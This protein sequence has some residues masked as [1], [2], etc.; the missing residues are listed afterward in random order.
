MSSPFVPKRRTAFFV[1]HGIGQQDPFE[2]LDVF[3][4]G[5]ANLLDE[6][7][8]DFVL[9]HQLAERAGASGGAWTESFCRFSPKD[10]DSSNANWLIDV[11]EYYW[12]YLTQEKIGEE[13]IWL[14]LD[15]TIRGAIRF[16]EENNQLLDR[17][18][19][20][21]RPY[22]SKLNEILQRLRWIYPLIRLAIAVL[23]RF[24]FRWA[25]LLR[26]W[27]ENRATQFIV[28]YIGDIAIY[29]T[30]DQ[31]SRH[32]RVR[33]QIL[34]E[35]FKLLEE[36]VT[37]TPCDQVILAGHSL[38][39]VIAYDTLNRLSILSSHATGS[40][41]PLS[42]LGGLVTFGSPLDKIA[43]FFREHTAQSQYVRR[44]ILEQLYSFKR[45]PFSFH[46]NAHVVV[47]PIQPVLEPLPWVNYYND[48]DPISGYLDFY[49]RLDNVE[50]KLASG[51]GV[52]HVEYWIHP[53][54]YA[55]IARR[56]L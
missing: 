5:I 11:H 25:R 34:K 6:A 33:Q 54:F 8:V 15:T 26:A 31:K 41:M 29:S 27:L 42:K 30:T 49:H 2:T 12:A 44:Q 55:D 18:K 1:V 10:G 48:K 50:L 9:S 39:S 13:E 45:R 17:F 37:H 51:W 23:K 52:A 53:P 28:D 7:G 47:S 4:R 46:K 36:V 56:F 3:A 40:T 24:H 14:W 19:G 32:F 21:N 22:W 43:F 35:S 16:Y 20:N 38:G